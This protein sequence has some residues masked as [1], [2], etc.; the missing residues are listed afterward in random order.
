MQP[1][2]RFSRRIVVVK[3]ALLIANL[4]FA[5]LLVGCGG[6]AAGSGQ[7]GGN[8]GSGGSG[9]SDGSG[10]GSGGGNG[11]TGG[12]TQ[13]CS[14][15]SLGSGANLNG[16][17]PFASDNLWNKDISASP[18]DSNSGTIISTI[19]STIGLHPDFGTGGNGIPYVVVNGTQNLVG[20]NFTAY[21]D[22]SDPGFMPIP[23]SAPIEGGSN[24]T[25]DRH[26]LVLDNANCFLYELDRSFVRS[27]GSWDADSAAIWDLL[28]NQQR[29]WTW[30]SADAAGLPV[31]PGLARYDEVAAGQINHALRFTVHDSRK[32]FTP[33]ASH[34][35]SSNTSSSVGPMGMRLRLKANYD[36]SGFSAKN[37]VILTALKKYGMIL[38]DNGTS[39]FITGAPDDRWDDDDLHMLGQV[40]ASAF[41]VVQMNPVYTSANVPQGNAPAIS[42]LTAT[43]T[44]ISVGQSTTLSWTVS[45]ASYLIMSPVPG[46]VRGTSVTVSPTRTTTYTLYA[47]N[48]YGQSSSNITITVQ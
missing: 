41:E 13:S 32:A 39:M 8:M 16:F 2:R 20:I 9:G 47:T 5:V 3:N 48:Q 1:S 15:M 31:F 7:S 27:D 21:G 23:S 18:V 26:V 36:I 12:N 35:A 10:G 4:L 29:P 25:G 30:T 46:P 11:G 6:G 33:P 19:G 42:G 45:G 44:T 34:W 14:A 28:G 40:Q 37:Q 22:E 24:S 38:A 17:V 43:S